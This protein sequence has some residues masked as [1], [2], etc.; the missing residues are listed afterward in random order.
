MTVKSLMS[1]LLAVAKLLL[2]LEAWSISRYVVKGMRWVPRI[3]MRIVRRNVGV[4]MLKGKV[5]DRRKV[6]PGIT[7]RTLLVYPANNSVRYWLSGMR[8]PSFSEADPRLYRMQLSSWGLRYNVY[9]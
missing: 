5:R 6:S 8:S 9:L 1:R 3:Q 7:S 4:G 2:G